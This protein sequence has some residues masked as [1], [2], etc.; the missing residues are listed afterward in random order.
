M[1]TNFE[2][3]FNKVSEDVKE[4]IKTDTIIGEEFTMGDYT[5]KPV[6]KVGVGFGTGTGN[7]KGHKYKGNVEGE[8]AGAG[9]GIG[10]APVGFL[11]TKGDEITFI[12]ANNKNG[13]SSVLEKIP[14][15]MEK[16][17][18]MKEKKAEEPKKDK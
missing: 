2:N 16:F 17:M 6:I 13:L 4:L 18:E 8:H 7:G 10:I 12:P 15:L 3:V 5:C 11:A 14:D 9:A 1:E